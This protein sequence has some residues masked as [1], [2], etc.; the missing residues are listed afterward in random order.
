MKF[1]NNTK[2]N[3]KYRTGTLTEGYDWNNVRPTET[4]DIPWASGKNTALT[5]V[6]GAKDEKAKEDQSDAEPID[7]A[8]EY[9]KK[10]VDINGVGKK[11]AEEIIAEHPTEEALKEAI[12]K[13]EEIHKRD[14]VDAK[15]KEAFN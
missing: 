11:S 12:T 1:K 13:G 4:V 2:E 10:L 6:G 15:I 7:E 9:F 8:K 5:A 14:D 3:V